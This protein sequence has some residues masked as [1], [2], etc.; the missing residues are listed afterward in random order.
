[1]CVFSKNIGKSPEAKGYETNPRFQLKK[2]KQTKKHC[3][4]SFLLGKKK[5]KWL[6]AIVGRNISLIA[7]DQLSWT[8]DRPEESD[9]CPFHS[10]TL[11]HCP[12]CCGIWKQYLQHT[13]SQKR[14]GNI[15][16]K[17]WN[18]AEVGSKVQVDSQLGNYTTVIALT[19]CNCSVKSSTTRM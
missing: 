16:V 15:K 6:G 10:S 5:K 1:M 8:E 9:L 18:L 14:R 3:K 11:S 2:T 19:S 12:L 7:E 17:Y 13:S 4:K